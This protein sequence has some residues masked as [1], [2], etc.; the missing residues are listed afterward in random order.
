MPTSPYFNNLE[1]FQ[2]QELLQDLV[3]EF[4]SISGVDAFYL[5]R[6]FENVDKTLNEDTLTTFN[7]AYMIVVF[8]KDNVG[9]GGEGDFLSKFGLEIR[10]T[11]TVSLA[12][13]E[14]EKCVRLP[15]PDLLRPNEGDLIYLPFCDNF[16]EITHVEHEAVFY[17]MGKIQSYDISTQ[18][19]EYSHE[20]FL[21]GYPKIDTYFDAETTTQISSLK[22]LEKKDNISRNKHYHDELMPI[23]NWDDVDPFTET[24]SKPSIE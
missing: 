6:K 19:F 8:V 24:I 15:R 22:E 20:R 21:T 10:D 4:I 3:N 9:F 12:L 23:I 14:F 17:A 13:R 18:L 7:G 11:M 2:E 5:T 1:H 16:Y